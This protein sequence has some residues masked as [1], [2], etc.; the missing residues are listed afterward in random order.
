M[1]RCR[2][3]HGYR[4]VPLG[5]GS[6]AGGKRTRREGVMGSLQF[7]RQGP[8]RHSGRSGRCSRDCH[9]IALIR[10]GTPA[11]HRRVPPGLDPGPALAPH[12]P[13]LVACLAFRNGNDGYGETLST[14]S[15]GNAQG[16]HLSFRIRTIMEVIVCHLARPRGKKLAAVLYPLSLGFGSIMKTMVRHPAMS[17]GRML[18]AS[19]RHL[20]SRFRMAIITMVALLSSCG[21]SA[22]RATT[23]PR[24]SKVPCPIRPRR[25]RFAQRHAPRSFPRRA[26]LSSER[27]PR[28]SR[29][30]PFPSPI[31]KFVGMPRKM[32]DF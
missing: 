21:R 8:G 28:H 4:Q 1:W 12:L 7:Q 26:P 30:S 17:H 25:R 9:A 24:A 3:R 23:R 2:R 27:S 19:T 20:S 32:R 16:S 18:S 31:A 6:T 13:F 22:D 14:A 29:K 15:R 5:D 10:P 11:M